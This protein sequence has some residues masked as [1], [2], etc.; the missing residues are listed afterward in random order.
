MFDGLK[1][2]VMVALATT[3]LASV[4]MS[5][6]QEWP[7]YRDA[8]GRFEFRYPPEY[9]TPGRGTDDGFRDRVAAVRFSALTGLGGEAAVTKGRVVI[10][11]Q[12]A[13]GL[14]DEITLQVFPEPVRQ[15]IEA[16]VPPLTLQNF[17]AILGRQDHIQADSGL[18]P[19]ILELVRSADRSRNAD[20]K[21][22]QCTQS[23]SVVTFHKE[24][25][26]ISGAVKTRQHL[27]G[28]VRFLTP[29]YSSF[30][31]V[32]GSVLPPPGG[33]LEAITKMV[34]SFAAK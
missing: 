29:P 17:C 13:G 14:Y 19:K 25:T 24:A 8:R 33:A 26:F 18:D 7:T 9:G 6:V 12:A 32:L 21:V 15:R 30:Q 2:S 5:A 11:L 23:G 3:A 10:D 20:P 34:G 4:K 28:A 22:V 16:V 27:Y 1:S 31:F